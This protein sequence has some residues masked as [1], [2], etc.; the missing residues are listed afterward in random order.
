MHASLYNIGAT[1]IPMVQKNSSSLVFF[2]AIFL[3][4]HILEKLS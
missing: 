2:T 1:T 4:C 3:F